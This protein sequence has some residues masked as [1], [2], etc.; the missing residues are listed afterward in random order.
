MKALF[1]ATISLLH[2]GCASSDNSPI[3]SLYD[4]NGVETLKVREKELASVQTSGNIPLVRLK[5]ESKAQ[6]VGDILGGIGIYVGKQVISGAMNYYSQQG[7][8]YPLK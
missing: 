7:R 1:I 6:V 4:K 5:K 2:I 8:V 3:A